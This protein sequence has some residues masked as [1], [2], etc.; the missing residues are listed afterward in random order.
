MA[1]GLNCVIVA[2]CRAV[3]CGTVNYLPLVSYS[4]RFNWGGFTGSR[5]RT[6]HCSYSA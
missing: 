2:L 1:K 5:G 6:D 3:G 4:K